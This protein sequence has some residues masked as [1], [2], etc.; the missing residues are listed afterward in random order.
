MEEPKWNY[1]DKINDGNTYENGD[2]I[3]TVDFNKILENINYL[4]IRL[5]GRID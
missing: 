2:A 4:K 3:K 5:N 1:I